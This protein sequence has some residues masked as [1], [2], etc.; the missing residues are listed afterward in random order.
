MSNVID[1][2]QMYEAT[3]ILG[4]LALWIIFIVVYAELRTKR[5]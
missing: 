3:L 4:G 5:K 1:W 2:N